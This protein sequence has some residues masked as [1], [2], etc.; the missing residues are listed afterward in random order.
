[1]SFSGYNFDIVSGVTALVVAP[2]AARGRAPRWLLIAW[3]ALGTSLLAAIVV[4]ALL[5][6]PL[7]RA[8]GSEPEQV[9]TWV[10][11]FPYVLLPA[12]LVTAALAG[13]VVVWRA[14]A[15]TRET[16]A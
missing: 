13:H 10:T 15:A 8:F 11:F 3:N 7:V 2:L 4:V 5:A 9:N 6:S 14:L 1:M 16:P 12:V